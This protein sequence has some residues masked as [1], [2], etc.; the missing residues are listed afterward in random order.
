M[1]AQVVGRETPFVTLCME[2][3]QKFHFN[4]TK[5]GGDPKICT[6]AW[7]RL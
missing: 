5:G 4:K 7:R 1:T 3:K 6:F 2:F